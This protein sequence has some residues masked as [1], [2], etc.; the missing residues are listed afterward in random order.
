MKLNRST[1]R[2]HI[3]TTVLLGTLPTVTAVQ[4]QTATNNPTQL[5]PV[6][7]SA[8]APALDQKAEAGSRLGVP[9]R[10]VPASVFALDQDSFRSRGHRTM[11]EAVESVV[12]FSGANSPGNGATF[13]SRGFVGDAVS[14]YFDGVKIINPAMS[15]RLL[16]TFNYGS[17][18]VLKGPAAVLFGEGGVGGAVN[19]VPKEPNRDRFQGEA[20]LG[21]G[22]FNST[23][24]GVGIGGPVGQSGVSYRADFSRQ[25]S[26]TF[27]DGAG[28][29]LYNLTGAVGWDVSDQFAM[30]LYVEALKDDN[31]AYFGTPLVNG[32]IDE[33]IRDISYNISDNHMKAE[34]LWLRLKSEWTP[35]E[36]VRVRNLTY[37]YL[38]GRDWRN[39]EGFDYD[40]IG[41][42]VTIR[43]LGIVEHDQSL[44][45]NRLDALFTGEIGG[46]ENR[47]VLGGDVSGN[48]FFR[49]AYFPS[50]ALTVNAYA[51][52]VGPFSAYA[53]PSTTA[54]ADYDLFQ[55][56]LFAEDQ[57]SVLPR[58]KLV[59]GVRWD[60]IDLE[61]HNRDTG[62]DYG[63]SFSPVTFRGGV[64]FEVVTNLTAYASYATGANPPRSFVNNNR[65]FTYGLE[66]SQQIE[67]GLK[68]T[69]W[70]GRMEA[71]LAVFHLTKDR[72]RTVFTGGQ[73]IG[74]PDGR[75]KSEGVEFDARLRPLAG[76]T[77][78][79]NVS[80]LSS[81]IEDSPAGNSGLVA[82]NVP[83][84]QANLFTSYA[85]PFGLELGAALRYVGKRFADDGDT[86]VLKEY[87][88]LDLHA[89]YRWKK[90][91]FTVRGR[92]VT[93]ELH[94]AWSETDYFNTQPQ[95][96]VGA[97]ATV[98]ALVSVKF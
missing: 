32:R 57:F 94:A 8:S 9:I 14:Q 35:N 60:H 58:L 34:S 74:V 24:I 68:H 5:N 52:S 90:W 27:V 50:S 83:R 76:W 7:V 98:E 64:V 17:V 47:L 62:V 75:V 49:M 3:L 71:T 59:G 15:A 31:H 19:F 20:Q 44:V 55:G 13:S 86:F 93:D 4:A 30:T 54:G 97:P 81:R 16:D 41:G 6:V 46:R 53:G 95:V 12:G 66:E 89:T 11:L 22:S 63:R 10:E 38:A 77:V 1:S 40:P 69:C 29:E 87:A 23:R 25:S 79:G 56:A 91:E 2:Q 70:D 78:G 37:G 21:Y 80:V 39:A 33:R 51:P 85:F 67:A 96:L 36:K 72:E 48:S 84:Q 28:L 26:D 61:V 43:D 88:T 45:G 65:P 82:A 73:R 42:T 92:N 18:E